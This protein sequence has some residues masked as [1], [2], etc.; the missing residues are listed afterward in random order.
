MT[1]SPEEGPTRPLFPIQRPWLAG[2]LTGMTVGTYLFFY[3]YVYAR[4]LKRLGIKV[5]PWLWLLSPAIGLSAFFTYPKMADHFQALARDRGVKYFHFGT[6]IG[7]A[8]FVCFVANNVADRFDYGGMVLLLTVPILWFSIA[9]FTSDINI[10]K[11]S[12]PES[13]FAKPAYSTT[14]STWIFGALILF[15]FLPIFGYFVFSSVEEVSRDRVEPGQVWSLKGGGF[16]VAP[17]DVWFLADIGTFSDG[18]A[19]AEFAMRDFRS[20]IVFDQKDDNSAVDIAEFRRNDFLDEFSDGRCEQRRWLRE[21]SM[22]HRSE[23]ICSA[24]FF[25]DP[26]VMMSLSIEDGDRHL[27]I[28]GEMNS[29]S[30]TREEAIAKLRRFGA[31]TTFTED[32]STND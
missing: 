14:A 29:S 27:E 32:I 20:A 3:L 12:L 2:L 7:I 15:V 6:W 19:V 10:A 17:E 30:D 16:T 24:Q 26:V 5:R 31:A 21:G 22:E 11:R 25:G 18:S 9:R 28:L 4:D 8:V 13:Y 23:V 1:P